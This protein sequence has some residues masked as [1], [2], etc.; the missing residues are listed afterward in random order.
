MELRRWWLWVGCLVAGVTLLAACG[1]TQSG[2]TTSATATPFVSD[3]HN[4]ADITFAQQS[5]VVHTSALRLAQLGAQ[6]SNNPQVLEWAQIVERQMGPE[7]AQ[8]R[9]LLAAWSAPQPEEAGPSGDELA[10]PAAQWKRLEQLDGQRFTNV[11]LRT[12]RGLLTDQVTVAQAEL[13]D[14][15]NAE[16]RV[17]AEKFVTVNSGQVRELGRLIAAEQ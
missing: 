2:G 5:L 6:K 17:L 10:V 16:A 3:Q 15:E 1:S 4:A 14:G 12:L 9:Q 13:A 7:I 11:W 8:L